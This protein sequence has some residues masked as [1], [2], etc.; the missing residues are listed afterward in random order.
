MSKTGQKKNIKIFLEF[1]ESCVSFVVKKGLSQKAYVPYGSYGYEL[2]A[3][4]KRT[5]ANT[6]SRNEFPP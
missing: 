5:I 1:K 4:T 6:S 2:Y 3:V